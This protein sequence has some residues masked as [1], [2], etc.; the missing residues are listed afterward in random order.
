MKIK[1][2][3]DVFNARRQLANQKQKRIVIGA[4]GIFEFGWIPTEIDFLDILKPHDWITL[5]VPNS[6]DAML[7][8]H[9]W[10]HLT[11]EE[12]LIAAQFCYKYLKPG[13][14]LRVAVP[15]GFNSNNDYIESVRV[16]G[17]GP[18][19]DDHKVLYTYITFSNLFQKAGFDVE[20]L[21]YFDE[22]HN[23]H[24]TEWTPEQGKIIRS[25]RFDPRNQTG[26]LNYTSLILDARK[27]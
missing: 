16:G 20:L 22:H 27:R 23:F 11:Q 2:F 10:E 12:G 19:A 13:G 17:S 18:G 9:V 24:H 25:K 15:D 7:A 5:F 3:K 1:R 8:E 14:Y 6:L 21:E 4:S 26:A